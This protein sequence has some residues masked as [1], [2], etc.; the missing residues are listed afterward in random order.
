[1]RLRARVS[2]NVAI[3]EQRT[4]V[5]EVPEH[6]IT[7]CNGDMSEAFLKVYNQDYDYHG[8]PWEVVVNDVYGLG[9]ISGPEIAE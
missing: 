1:M 4:V 6:I 3:Q 5:L 9:I 8:G 2:R 7:Q